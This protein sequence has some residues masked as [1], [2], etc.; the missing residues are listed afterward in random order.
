MLPTDPFTNDPP[1]PHIAPVRRVVALR[2]PPAHGTVILAREFRVW[3]VRS[4]G[5]TGADQGG[6]WGAYLAGYCV[7]DLGGF[8]PRGWMTERGPAPW[9][10]LWG[11]R[12]H[13]GAGPG[14][15]VAADYAARTE[16]NVSAA[17]GTLIVGDR[18]S[19]GTVK[20]I[21]ACQSRRR[22]YLVVGW[23][24]GAGATPRATTVEAVQG[25]LRTNAVRTLNVAGNRESRAPGIFEATAALVRAVLLEP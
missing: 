19:R 2:P 24:P 20:T 7:H 14:A 25:W 23:R 1:W 9:L 17:H 21:A 22:P 6:L 5:Q 13:E 11:L 16:A 18:T 3:S 12:E 4:G 10:A 15:S 8:A